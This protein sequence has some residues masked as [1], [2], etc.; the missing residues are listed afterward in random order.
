MML[1]L[2]LRPRYGTLDMTSHCNKIQ[3][4][5]VEKPDMAGKAVE[6]ELGY[7]NAESSCM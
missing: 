7:K 1:N 3:P 2:G 6:L 4:P 5:S